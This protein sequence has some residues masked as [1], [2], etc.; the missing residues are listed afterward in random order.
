[1]IV[2]ALDK[3]QLGDLTPPAARGLRHSPCSS[4]STTGEADIAFELGAMLVGVTTRDSRRSRLDMG[5]GQLS[6][7]IRERCP[8]GGPA[9]RRESGIKE[10]PPTCAPA[11]PAPSMQ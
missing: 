7:K 9:G 6:A 4:R 10:P 3:V 8:R 11:R 5:G 2:A 1:M